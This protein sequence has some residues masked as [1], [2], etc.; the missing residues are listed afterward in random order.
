MV[1]ALFCVYAYERDAE[2]EEEREL[3]RAEVEGW[4]CGWSE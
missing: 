1:H 3:A 4:H 2:A